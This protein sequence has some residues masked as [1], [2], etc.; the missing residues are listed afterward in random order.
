M[1]KYTFSDFGNN[2]L[3]TITFVDENV[4]LDFLDPEWQIHFIEE[5]ERLKPK[6]INDL[7]RSGYSYY[8][9]AKVDN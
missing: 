4:E 8:K 3:G 1:E 9:I 2:I 7:F 5:V 6:N